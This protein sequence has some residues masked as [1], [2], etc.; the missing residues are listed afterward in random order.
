MY[1]GV[2]IPFSYILAVEVANITQGCTGIAINSYKA[3]TAQN[4]IVN[5]A[6]DSFYSPETIKL[7]SNDTTCRPVTKTYLHPNSRKTPLIMCILQTESKLPSFIG[8]LGGFLETRCDIHTYG[9]SESGKRE[10]KSLILDPVSL[11]YTEDKSY[12]CV[13]LAKNSNLCSTDIGGGI[14]CDGS[15][16]GI[17]VKTTPEKEC[18]AAI[19][20]QMK[21][22]FSKLTASRSWIEITAQVYVNRV[23]ICQY[24]QFNI[25]DGRLFW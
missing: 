10:R 23:L 4:C 13:K 18:D 19:N 17:L 6:T 15:L 20:E 3:M 25:F 11:C 16:V 9:K 5:Y 7:C 14:I 22:L 1:G 21:G 24:C 12:E 8:F 2:S